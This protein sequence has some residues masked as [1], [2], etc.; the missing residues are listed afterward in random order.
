MH[1]IV[2]TRGSKLALTQTNMMITELKKVDPSHTYEVKIITTQGDINQSVPLSQVGGSGIFVKEIE[3]A[4]LN[5]EIDIAIHSLKDM[6][7]K[8]PEGLELGDFPKRENPF[9]VLITKKGIRS[10]SDMSENAVIGTGSLRRQFQL[11]TIRPDLVCKPIRGNI[12]SR[13]NKIGETCDGVILAKAGVS[14]LGVDQLEDYDYIT[15]TL[16]DMVPSPCQ[17]ILGIQYR[18][19]ANELEKEAI[20]K[21]L[22]KSVSDERTT[23]QATVERCF[24]K[25]VGSNCH[26]PIGG[27]LEIESDKLTFHALLG[28]ENGE[29]MIRKKVSGARET[30][31]DRVEALAIELMKEVG[32]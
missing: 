32:L 20:F 29:N 22:V 16:D 23:L 4:L 2:G 13:I 5:K 18:T 9:D 12:D 6:P 17:G 1:I 28:R 25:T 31:L 24:L 10:L 19:P 30:I 26:I 11:R 27:Y 3:R 7:S 15:F 21:T 8:L 14:R